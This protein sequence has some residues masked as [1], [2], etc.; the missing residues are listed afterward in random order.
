MSDVVQKIKAH[1]DDQIPSSP[2]TEALVDV[3]AALRAEHRPGP[4][5]DGPDDGCR[6]CREV[7]ANRRRCVGCSDVDG[8]ANLWPCPTIRAVGTALGVREDGD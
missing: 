4:L 6:L 3:I 8:N 7:T 5:K 1:I 2:G